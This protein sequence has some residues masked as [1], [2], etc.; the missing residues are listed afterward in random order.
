MDYNARM[1]QQF[2]GTQQQQGRGKKK[3]ED[4][5]AFMRLVRVSAVAFSEQLLIIIAAR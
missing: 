5:D 2:R 4:P 1:S 3:D